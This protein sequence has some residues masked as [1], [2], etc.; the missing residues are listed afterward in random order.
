M[1]LRN[2]LAWSVSGQFLSFAISFSGSMV[3]ARLLTPYD[4]GVYAIALAIIGVLNTLAAFGVGA[5]VVRATE[6]TPTTL[7]SAFTLNA[8]L[9]LAMATVIFAASV[10][11]RTQFG[12]PAVAQ[13][14]VPLALGPLIGI[15]EFRPAVML[16]REMNF[17]VLS[18]IN[19]VR[20]IVATLVVIG[21]AVAGFSY[22]S[23][24]YSNLVSAVIGVICV[25][26]VAGQHAGFRLSLSEGRKMAMFG[27]RMMS[28]GG[29]NTLAARVSEIVL[30]NLLGLAALGLYS[31]AANVSNQIFDNV[32]GAVTRVLFVKLSADFRERGVL[33][34]VFLRGFEMITA[35]IWPLLIGLAV[36]S[37][38]A[39]Y[40][41]Y[42]ERWIEAA[43]P[44]SLLLVAQFVVISFGMNWELFVLRDETAKQVRFEAVRAVVGVLTFS[45][46]CLFSISTAAVGRIAEAM[47]G[48]ALYH[49]HMTRMADAEPG[50]LVR[51]YGRGLALTVVAAL[52]AFVLMIVTDWS[53]KTSPL[54]IA[55]AV[56][57]GMLMW[58][59]L[60]SRL[61]HPLFGEIRIIVRKMVFRPRGRAE[62][63]S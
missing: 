62:K 38:P 49:P 29:L 16:Q 3:V 47:F 33:R 6:L 54:L 51:I 44:L 13:V 52:P 25:N 12:S 18:L 23:L 43:L 15:L 55:S 21:L 22:M 28:I 39:V 42:G 63:A 32:Y 36:L 26:L 56:L 14:L 45:I 34:D 9:S 59:A 5:Y 50:E 53:Y 8:I 10:I 27:L 2:A 57:A 37:R 4:M 17:R 7:S 48:W 60:L 35:L 30:G 46:G 1:A 11:E 61:D 24:A 19:I 40:I 20:V 58:L 31:R 41:L